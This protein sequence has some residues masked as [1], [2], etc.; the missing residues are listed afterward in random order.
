MFVKLIV[1]KGQHCAHHN[2][3]VQEGEGRQRNFVG[4]RRDLL[5]VLHMIED[6][7]Q[8]NAAFATRIYVML[9]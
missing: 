3:K 1:T 2:R 7:L 9:E 8:L 6:D 5:D 4:Q